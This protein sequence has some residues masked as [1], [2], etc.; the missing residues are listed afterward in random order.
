MTC[1]VRVKDRV[2]SLTPGELDLLV[3]TC[4]DLVKVLTSKVELFNNSKIETNLYL[5]DVITDIKNVM[6][7]LEKP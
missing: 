1:L 7:K 3:D 4:K 5:L 2:I 6:H